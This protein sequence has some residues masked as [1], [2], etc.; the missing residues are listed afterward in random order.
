MPEPK[1]DLLKIDEDCFED[2]FYNVLG[3]LILK[4]KV[5]S[6]VNNSYHIFRP[7][8]NLDL[9][10]SNLQ[11][12]NCYSS[13]I[14]S[15]FDVFYEDFYDYNWIISLVQN[16]KTYPQDYPEFYEKYGSDIRYSMAYIVELVMFEFKKHIILL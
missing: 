9:N 3:D 7:I 8:H 13:S 16:Y 5:S 6:R 15:Y 4:Y 1:I 14:Y 11:I 12:Y 2:L 10:N